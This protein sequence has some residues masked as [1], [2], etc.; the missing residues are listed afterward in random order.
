[1]FKMNKMV[2]I[3]RFAGNPNTNT[4]GTSTLSAEMKTF[5]D[6]TLID[7]A[8]PE[9][10][11]DQFGQE[12][13][14]PKNGGKTIEFRKFTALPKA[15][16]PL[17]EGV[18]PDGRSLSVT[19]QTATVSQYGDYVTLSDM[20]EMTAIDNTIVETLSLIG[21][22]AGR[23]LDTVTREKL[24]AG[25]NV[26]YQP[27][28]SSTGETAVTSRAGLTAKNV[29][30]VKE[31]FRAAAALKAANAK[32]INGDF[33]AIIHPYVAYDLMMEAGDQW[34]DIQKYQ[35]PENI[36]NGEIGKIGGV[37]FV[38]TTEAKIWK[39]TADN[40]ADGVAVFG[41]LFIA[42]NAYGKT[43]VNGGGLETIVKQKGSGGTSDPLDQRS[44]IGWK[45]VK[46]A[47]I[48]TEEYMIRVESGSSW[49]AAAQ[50]N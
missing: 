24:A 10:V 6:K 50:A 17:T 37:R 29:L 25:T 45:A 9:L 5:Y 3:Q 19:S 48:L 22:Q 2:D 14:I 13:N 12:R 40:C 42:A 8:E 41:T 28:P 7:E 32:P 11:H 36:Y 4:T 20:L 39:G 35:H 26:M 49:N 27:T 1:M 46:T 33:V 43:S 18:T 47:E 23:T 21:S 31:V 15:T 38:Q 16:T 44:T 30:T 34:I